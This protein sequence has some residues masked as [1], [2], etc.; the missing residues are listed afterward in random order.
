MI[1][2]LQVVDLPRD[3]I[4]VASDHLLKYLPVLVLRTAG[5][6]VGEQLPSPKSVFVT[7]Q[8]RRM[9]WREYL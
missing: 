5:K 1:Q 2:N 6:Q 4:R 9:T 8:N 3:V 7:D